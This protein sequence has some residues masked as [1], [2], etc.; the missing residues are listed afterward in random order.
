MDAA[1]AAI[2]VIAIVAVVLTRG[3]AYLERKLTFWSVNE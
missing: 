2:V 3:V 1:M